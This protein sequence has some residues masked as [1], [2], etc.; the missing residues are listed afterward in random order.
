MNSFTSQQVE[1]FRQTHG[2]SIEGVQSEKYKPIRTFAE[3]NVHEV[4]YLFSSFQKKFQK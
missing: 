2:I 1:Q 4:N 3:A